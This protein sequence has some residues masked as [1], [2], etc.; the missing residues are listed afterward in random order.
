MN[1]EFLKLVHLQEAV[2]LLID[3]LSLRGASSKGYEN[4]AVP[5]SIGRVLAEEILAPV[6]L[7]GFERSS[8]DGYAVRAA[9]TFGAGEGLPAYLELVGEVH[10]GALVEVEVGEGSA[11]RISTG[12]EIPP[13]A[14][15]VVIYENTDLSGD[16][17]E[18]VKAVAP[19]ENILLANED[20]SQ[21]SLLLSPGTIIGPAHI[22]ALSG[23][24]IASI[25]VFPLPTVGVLSTGDELVPT[26]GEP[27]TGQVRD[28][29]S[30]ALAAAVVASG[31]LPEPRGIVPDDYE[32]L[33][34][35][36]RE[37]ISTVD[38]LLISGGSSA[39]VKD[40]TVRVLEALGP[41]G[42]LAHGL[43]IKP[44]KPTLIA[45]CD[46]KPVL[47][48]P[49]NPASALAIFREL[50]L[51]VIRFMRGEATG[52][53]P[54]VPKRLEAE[55]GRTVSSDTGRLDLVP[56]TVSF[57]EGRPVASPVLGKSSLIGTLARA[58]GQV[59]VPVGVEGIMRGEVVTVELF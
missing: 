9:D 56:V 8:M 36:A 10:M 54:V 23:M 11:V 2:E 20:V 39:G 46:G 34:N 17:V 7:P 16:T 14:D 12:G 48:L 51:P 44:G 19:G 21:G 32:M 58:D 59:R 42:V 3:R 24:G 45:V 40:M 47:G 1:D 52:G 6:D 31:A 30:A 15:A 26:D 43:Y 33:L 28:I 4:L 27:G 29:N 38:M 35:R 57:K 18:V 25:R 55:L 22:G 53:L 37:A 50:V 49:G 41:P 5:D 13:G